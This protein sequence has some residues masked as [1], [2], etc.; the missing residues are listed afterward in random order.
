[1]IKV[2]THKTRSFSKKRINGARAYVNSS[3]GKVVDEFFHDN[4][5]YALKFK[6]N[7]WNALKRKAVESDIAD[8]K[9]IFGEEAEI[10][11]SKTAGCSCGCSPGYV[12]DG[13]IDG[14]YRNS[15]VWIDI[16]SSTAHLVKLLPDFTKKL[17]AEIAKKNS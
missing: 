10:R 11:W 15:D 8:L 6:C 5:I 14:K 16:D 9:I 7:T 12:V 17:T 3:V 4:K 13:K 1:M 2:T